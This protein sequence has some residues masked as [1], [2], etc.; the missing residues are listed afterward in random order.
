MGDHCGDRGESDGSS[1]ED[2]L[3]GRRAARALL[4]L[5]PL[6]LPASCASDS[7][8]GP[9]R[10]KVA[11]LS[12]PATARSSSVPASPATARALQGSGRVGSGVREGVGGGL[13]VTDGMALQ[14]ELPLPPAPPLLPLALRKSAALQPLSTEVMA[15]SE[16]L[17]L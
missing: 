10:R 13:R 14:Q 9:L 11:L 12:A 6:P 7:A 3:R 5:L 2:L 4:A 15:L 8:R 17:A 16:P 1:G